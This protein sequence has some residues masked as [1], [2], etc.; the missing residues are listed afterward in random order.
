MFV[1]PFWSFS[2]SNFA[3]VLALA[4]S[5]H[6]SLDLD[7]SPCVFLAYLIFFT[8]TKDVCCS[9]SF[10]V[11]FLAVFLGRAARFFFC[12]L[13]CLFC[14]LSSTV[15]SFIIVYFCCIN[16]V[17]FVVF[18]GLFVMLFFSL[19]VSPWSCV[20]NNAPP[21]SSRAPPH[22][23]SVSLRS[24][25]PTCTL[26]THVRTLALSSLANMWLCLCLCLFMFLCVCWSYCV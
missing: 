5:K 25:T 18:W 20:S 11:V 1:C 4:A 3:A 15:Y 16:N 17:V 19:G 2:C 23:L 24:T 14:P 26:P 7:F 12:F 22:P 6:Y 8:A 9:C 21:V 10:V 13:L